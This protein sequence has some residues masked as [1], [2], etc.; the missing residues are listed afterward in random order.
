M[1]ACPFIQAKQIKNITI[2]AASR[3]FPRSPFRSVRGEL[4]TDPRRV[5]ID[6]AFVIFQ[7]RAIAERVADSL[8][9]QGG[10]EVLG[11]RG[12]VVWGRPRPAKKAVTATAVAAAATSV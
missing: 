8:T 11:K 9:A 3:K 4:P 2:V 10:I 1:S 7:D 6:C 5:R 12:K